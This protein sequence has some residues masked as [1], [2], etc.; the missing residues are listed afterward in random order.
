MLSQSFP[1]GGQIPI[2]IRLNPL[3]KIKLYRITAQ[4]EQKT[5]Y[6]A[7]GEPR[8]M[9]VLAACVLILRTRTN[10]QFIPAAS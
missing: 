1:I 7:S 8:S 9:H 10:L 2:S 5:S 6:F 4:L 3:A